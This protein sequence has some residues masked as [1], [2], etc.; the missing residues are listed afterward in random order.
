MQNRK[1]VIQTTN[2][3]SSL[4]SV[5]IVQSSTIDDEN[6]GP[7]VS[8]ENF[9]RE[10]EHVFINEEA[11]IEALKR[12]GYTVADL[13]YKPLQKFRRPGCDDTVTKLLFEK[14]QQKRENIIKQALEIREQVL[15]E[16]KQKPPETAIIRRTKRFIENEKKQVSQLQTEQNN[17]LRKLVLMQLRNL[18][19]TQQHMSA[20]ERTNSRIQQI[21]EEKEIQMK[22]IRARSVPP[23]R[24][25]QFFDIPERQ[26]L[27]LID[28]I[29]ERINQWR[30][31][32][33][34]KRQEKYK[35][36][37]EHW[38]SVFQRSEQ[39]LQQQNEEKERKLNLEREKYQR[40]EQEHQENLSMLNA[41]YKNR[42]LKA[43]SVIQARLNSEEE[44][45]QQILQK[46]SASEARSKSACDMKQAQT[47]KRVEELRARLDSRMA[48]VRETRERKEREDQ[49]R[50]ENYEKQDEEHKQKMKSM[51]HEQAMKLLAKQMD[52]EERAERAM[53]SAEG[54]RYQKER[55]LIIESGDPTELKK[56]SIEKKNI[57]TEKQRSTTRYSI[58][59]DQLLTELNKMKGP[60][61]ERQLAKIQSILCIDEEE[62]QKIIEAAKPSTTVPSALR[63]PNPATVSTVSVTSIKSQA[64]TSSSNLPQPNRP[65]PTRQQSFKP[66]GKADLTRP[67]TTVNRMRK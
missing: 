18:Y 31:Q 21:E 16:K 29:Q 67:S 25:P 1:P 48:H 37:D 64:A 50:K 27:P 58:I 44:R 62:M 35:L 9:K 33:E 56:L 4:P 14:H 40:W 42:A 20:V 2:S 51:N 23:G 63:A 47:Q 53:R 46:I 38:K 36:K 5:S 10:S 52:R 43:Q 15:E 45:K 55:K 11:S 65:Q 22:A 30:K 12:M 13:H 3:K 49:E 7:K 24:G 34:Q 61:D 19:L 28:P 6:E 60:N 17:M 39:I 41:K 26:P 8:L 59:R 66:T 57:E 54:K 32:E